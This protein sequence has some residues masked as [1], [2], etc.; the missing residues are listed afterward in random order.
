MDPPPSQVSLSQHLAPAQV[1]SEEM[2]PLGPRPQHRAVAARRQAERRQEPAAAGLLRYPW[3]QR[4]GRTRHLSPS[5]PRPHRPATPGEEGTPSPCRAEPG[6][7]APGGSCS[8]SASAPPP[9]P[10]SNPGRLPEPHQ[11]V[12][13]LIIAHEI[14]LHVRHLG[15]RGEGERRN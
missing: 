10:T 9:H 8:R 6:R 12:V 11:V 15:R 3:V 2:G 13:L 7:R 14:I 1:Q 5:F 4:P